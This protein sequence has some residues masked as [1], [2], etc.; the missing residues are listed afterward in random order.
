M[1]FTSSKRPYYFQK[2]AHKTFK[3][4]GKRE[5]YIALSKLLS[6]GKLLSLE[7]FYN[8]KHCKSGPDLLN[9]FAEYFGQFI[10]PVTI[11]CPIQSPTTVS[12]SVTFKLKSQQFLMKLLD[13]TFTRNLAQM[14]FLLC[15]EVL[16]L[17]IIRSTPHY[18]Q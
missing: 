1:V 10:Q 5:D 12:T 16:Q 4:S 2:Q 6:E 7:M 13:W 18:F 11:Q 14:V 15:L 17:C 8:D 3:E 9:L